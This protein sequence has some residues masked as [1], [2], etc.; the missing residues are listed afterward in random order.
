MEDSEVNK[1]KC[2]GIPD[3]LYLSINLIIDIIKKNHLQNSILSAETN[4]SDLLPAIYEGL[5]MSLYKDMQ[6]F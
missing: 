3:I 2:D 6:Y 1:F 5:A 4:H